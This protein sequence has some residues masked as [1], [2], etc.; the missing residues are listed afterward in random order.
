MEETTI[1]LRE[2][3]RIL[4]KRKKLILRCFVGF[5]LAALAVSLV[6]P[7]TYEGESALKKKKKKGL[8][9]SLLGDL[10]TSNSSATKQLMSTYAEILKSR[11][12]V[13]ALIEERYGDKPREEKRTYRAR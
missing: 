5:L 11:T 13:N 6:W 12:V 2:V 3:L 10:P 9:D 8:G 4:R 1:D 7:P